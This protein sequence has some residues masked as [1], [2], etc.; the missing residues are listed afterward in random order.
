MIAPGGEAAFVGRMVEES[1][2]MK[3]RCR[4]V[5]REY[6]IRQR[7]GPDIGVYSSITSMLGKMTTL[8]HVVRLLK[9]K[10]ASKMSDEDIEKH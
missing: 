10:N 7:N 8:T 2:A 6:L 3:D 5:Y 9:E 1:L 4:R